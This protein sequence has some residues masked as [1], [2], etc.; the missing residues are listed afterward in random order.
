MLRDQDAP[1][2]P[3][4]RLSRFTEFAVL[5]RYDEEPDLLFR[6]LPEFVMNATLLRALWSAPTTRPAGWGWVPVAG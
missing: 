2:V 6:Q 1:I 5:R 3:F 4:I